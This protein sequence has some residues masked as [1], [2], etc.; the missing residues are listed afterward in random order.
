[1]EVQLAILKSLFERVDEL[2]AKEFRQHF[3]RQEVVVAGTNPTGVIVRETAR[4]APT[5]SREA[6]AAGRLRPNALIALFI[7]CGS[8]YPGSDKRLARR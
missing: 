4:R 6:S 7:M 1:M 2:A 3:L 8:R 5:T